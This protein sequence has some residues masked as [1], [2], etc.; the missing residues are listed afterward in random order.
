MKASLNA[1]VK[2]MV[3]SLITRLDAETSNGLHQ[4]EPYTEA[5]VLSIGSPCTQ[6]TEK[7][8]RRVGKLP[9]AGFIFTGKVYQGKRDGWIAVFESPDLSKNPK[10]EYEIYEFPLNKMVGMFYLDDIADLVLWI[11]NQLTEHT[12]KRLRREIKRR[13][14]YENDDRFGAWA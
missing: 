13:A 9:G 4:C 3:A 8:Y 6:K 5:T 14:A 2:E 7:G 10:N 12:S 1:K 11:N